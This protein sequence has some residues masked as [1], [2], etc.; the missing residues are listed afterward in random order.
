MLCKSRNS[1]ELAIK[2]CSPVDYGSHLL[3][4]AMAIRSKSVSAKFTHFSLQRPLL[5]RNS[6]WRAVLRLRDTVEGVVL[7]VAFTIRR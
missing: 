2:P 7:S 6:T 4:R 5:Y 3:D 1:T